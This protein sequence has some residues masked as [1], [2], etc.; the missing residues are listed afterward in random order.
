MWVYGEF[1]G[2]LVGV[3][4]WSVDVCVYGVFL[5]ALVCV[6]TICGCVG[7]CDMCVDMCAGCSVWIDG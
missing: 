6:W 5:D 4:V 7:V 1:V 3:S 2:V